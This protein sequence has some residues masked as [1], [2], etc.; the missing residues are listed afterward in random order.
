MM[1]RPPLPGPPFDAAARACVDAIIEQ[2]DDHYFRVRPYR[3][4]VAEVSTT[5][6]FFQIDLCIED[7]YVIMSG[8]DVRN[9][10]T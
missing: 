6:T 1:L 9:R 4:K 8:P 7:I 10:L 3:I 5:G 2:L